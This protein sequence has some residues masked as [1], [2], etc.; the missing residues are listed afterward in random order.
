MLRSLL[1]P[2]KERKERTLL[3]GL[4]IEQGRFEY[5]W[6]EVV[7]YIPLFWPV[8]QGKPMV[9]CW[10]PLKILY[11]PVVLALLDPHKSLLLNLLH[12]AILSFYQANLWSLVRS[13]PVLLVSVVEV[14]DVSNKVN[15]RLSSQSWIRVLIIWLPIGFLK[16]CLPSLCTGVCDEP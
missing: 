4:K 14:R 8:A 1:V 2:S 6:L 3:A 12:V 9:L 5:P 16:S 10:S 15:Q 11:F 13:E 7:G